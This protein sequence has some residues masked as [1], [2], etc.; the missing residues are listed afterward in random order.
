MERIMT[1]GGTGGANEI[2]QPD[3][4]LTPSSRCLS[5]AV[6][7]NNGANPDPLANFA[8]SRLVPAS[9]VEKQGGGGEGP[10]TITF[11]AKDGSTVLD[12][13]VYEKDEVISS[14]PNPPVLENREFVGWKSTSDGHYLS[15]GSTTATS[16]VTY[17]AT[18]RITNMPDIKHF[19]IDESGQNVG[20]SYT[21]TVP[22]GSVFAF[23]KTKTLVDGQCPSS[24]W[25]G[26]ISQYSGQ[27]E[28]LYIPYGPF[29]DGRGYN[30]AYSMYSGGKSSTG[31]VTGG[32]KISRGF[33]LVKEVNP[34]GSTEYIIHLDDTGDSGTEIM[35]LQFNYQVMEEYEINNIDDWNIQLTV[36]RQNLG[37]SISEGVVNLY[38]KSVGYSK[39]IMVSGFTGT[40]IVQFVPIYSDEYYPGYDDQFSSI[41]VNGSQLIVT[42]R[43]EGGTF[44]FYKITDSGNPSHYIYFGVQNYKPFF[45]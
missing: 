38:G 12:S 40:P 25:T 18:Y 28:K 1:Y 13:A 30:D 11:V 9:V 27:Y 6:A 24:E 26:G 43:E 29:A 5:K 34:D 41:T 19:F 33:I 14:A 22:L 7:I 37:Y 32:G 20:T 21:V 2:L 16:N 4:L 3:P 23:V 45:T 31:I 39:N 15:I 42:R 35:S 10:F 8:N 17:K 36:N 44:N